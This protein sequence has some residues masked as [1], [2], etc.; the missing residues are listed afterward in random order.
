MSP[1]EPLAS[2]TRRES[3]RVGWIALLSALTL[4]PLWV[5]QQAREPGT[6]VEAVTAFMEA[7]QERDLDRAYRLIA[8]GVPAGDAAAFLHPDAIGDWDL[9]AVEQPDGSDVFGEPVTVTIGTDQGTAEGTFTVQEHD[10]EYLLADPF[11]TVTVSASSYLWMQ[12]NDRTVPAPLETTWQD[13]YTGQAQRTL[14]L[15]P[16]V[17]R[18][19]GGDPVALLGDGD[20]S[21][22]D[23]IGTPLPEPGQDAAAALQTAVNDYVDACAEY[24]LTAPPGCPFATD[25]L[26]DT[27]DRRRVE[28]VRDPVW[29]VEE[30][31]VAAVAPGT[32]QYGEPVLL[33]EFTDPGRLTLQGTATEDWDAWEPFTAACRFGP[34]LLHVLTGPDGTL[35]VAPL[36]QAPADTCRGTE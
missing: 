9:L 5:W 2:R 29:T 27:A 8:T 33:V 28:E 1:T 15:L 20:E 22:A 3:L 11:Q 36:G 21:G 4:M 35:Q 19:F 7:L 12:V 31:P 13:W 18:F 26:V 16:G 25:G 10:G 17:Y 24:R 32:G 23:A 34:G 6:A 14:H 30:Y